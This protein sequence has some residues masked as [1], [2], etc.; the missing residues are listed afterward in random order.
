MLLGPGKNGYNV[1][2]EPAALAVIE[3]LH[4]DWPRAR[5]W[6]TGVEDL[7]QTTGHIIGQRIQF[8]GRGHRLVSF[9][10]DPNGL[11][12]SIDLIYLIIAD[13]LVVD[14]IE[15]NIREE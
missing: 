12:P 14:F 3:K 2:F 9:S 5:F 6:W 7:L 10:A 4:A 15:M 8:R 1:R 11:H 13:E